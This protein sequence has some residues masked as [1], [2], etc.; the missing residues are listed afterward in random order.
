MAKNEKEAREELE[1]AR[2]QARYIRD[3]YDGERKWRA[4]EAERR[5]NDAA[6]ALSRLKGK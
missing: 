1:A 5:V 4:R 6:R 2:R 3:Q